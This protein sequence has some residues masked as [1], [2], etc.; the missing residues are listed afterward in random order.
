MFSETITACDMKVGRREEVTEFM[1]NYEYSRSF[2]LG[3]RF[4]LHKK[5]RT[6]F[7]Q[8]PLSCVWFSFVCMGTRKWKLLIW[9]L[10]HD[11]D[12]RHAHSYTR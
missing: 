3:P 6:I 9:C 12:A 7:C 5:I 1:K 4:V 10:S 8:K 11:Q 2:Y